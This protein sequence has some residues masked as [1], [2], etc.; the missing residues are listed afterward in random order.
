MRGCLCKIELWNTLNRVANGTVQ[1]L[2]MKNTVIKY[3]RQRDKC[4]AGLPM[5]DR[6]IEY[7]RQTFL[8]FSDETDKHLYLPMKDICIKY[9][10]QRVKCDG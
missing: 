9:I 5:K 2:A 10:R 4:D 3:I 6:A 1:V 7:I 8:N